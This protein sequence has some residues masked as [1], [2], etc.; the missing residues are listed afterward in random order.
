MDG[1]I[2]LTTLLFLVLAVVVFL[3]LRS[4]LGRR[5]GEEQARYERYKA[6]QSSQST[7]QVQGRDKVVTV[8]QREREEAQPQANESRPLADAEERMKSFAVGN[9]GVA[10]GLVE[11]FRLDASF[12]PEH[13]LKGA[14]AAYEM[15]VTAFAEG[16]RKA[17]QDLLSG[18][19]FDGF[20]NAISDRESR[21]EQMDQ[22]FVGI[23][24]ADIIEAQVRNG[25]AELTVK[26]VSELIS[27]TRDRAGRVISGDP[28]RIREVTDIWTFARELASRNPNWRVVATQPAN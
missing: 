7:S 17:L 22:S 15:I 13:F 10:R 11:V 18:E 16:N 5:T 2:D 23:K 8:R 12:D 25:I 20:A 19:V 6:Q 3:K 1:K 27:A 14:R 9:S 28:K 4:V 24:G 21:G 26:F